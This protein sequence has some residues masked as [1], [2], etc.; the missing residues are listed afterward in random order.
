MTILVKINAQMTKEYYKTRLLVDS[1]DDKKRLDV[2]LSTK[3][4]GFSRAQIQAWITS[5]CVKIDEKICNKSRTL[6]LEGQN[7]CVTAELAPHVEDQAEAI[8]LSVIFEDEMLVVLAKPA[9]CVVHPGAGNRSGT[10]LNGLL[11]AYP[12]LQA[13]PRAG[14]V[15]RLDKDTSGVMVVAKTPLAYQALTHALAS[16]EVKREYKAI[17]DGQVPRSDTIITQFGRHPIARQK[18]AVV[19][20]GREAITHIQIAERL[21]GYT[22]LNVSLETGRTHQIRVHMQHIGHP[23]LGDPTYGKHRG[24]QQLDSERAAAVIAMRRQ[25]LHAYRLSFKHPQTG[26]ALSFTCPLPEDMKRLLHTLSI[27]T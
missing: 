7:I 13:L 25:A 18:M 6:V 3:I 20:T 16:R 12:S 23:I 17:V 1:T 22:L 4:V 26:V 9:G 10:L 21:Q 11:F 19:P 8:P 27:Q 15:H 2:F 14:I 5:D 24:F